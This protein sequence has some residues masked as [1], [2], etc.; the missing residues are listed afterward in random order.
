M[1]LRL[2][3]S[4]PCT[5]S[6]K[7]IDCKKEALAIVFCNPAD[8]LIGLARLSALDSLVDRPPLKS[9]DADFAKF[10]D[11]YKGLWSPHT[12]VRQVQR[13][14]VQRK[15][16]SRVKALELK[17]KKAQEE[18]KA[19][20]EL[21]Q[22][23]AEEARLR[24]EEAAQTQRANKEVQSD[25]EADNN[26]SSSV[27][28]GRATSR[29]GSRKRHTR[30]KSRKSSGTPRS[31]KRQPPVE[32]SPVP[33]P[34]SAS[35]SLQSQTLPYPSQIPLY[36]PY[37][38]YPSYPPQTLVPPATEGCK[39][40]LTDFLDAHEKLI[41]LHGSL[42]TDSIMPVVNALGSYPRRSS[43]SDTSSAPRSTPGSSSSSSSSLSILDR[44][45]TAEKVLLGRN[46]KVTGCIP[47]LTD[48]EMMVFG[49][50]QNGCLNERIDALE[51]LFK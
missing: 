2:R 50:E 39:Y 27:S 42:T 34:I 22:A 20:T 3:S 8:G 24:K 32:H 44:I 21:Q 35:S 36:P 26:N 51:K 38:L 6:Y 46:G 40:G 5:A 11:C 31:S 43:P 48:L 19:Q 13:P 7:T 37:P 4:T 29:R 15:S 41:Q 49:A 18:L 12:V 33:P 25:N 9:D 47:R 16:S 30:S 1:L 14:T 45:N 28:K 23:A 10:H 17:R